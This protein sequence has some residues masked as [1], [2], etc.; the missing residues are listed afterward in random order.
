MVCFIMTVRG[1]S[2]CSAQICCGTVKLCESRPPN[3]PLVAKQNPKKVGEDLPRFG[4]RVTIQLEDSHAESLQ[5]QADRLGLSLSAYLRMRL[6]EMA[7]ES[8]KE[9]NEAEGTTKTR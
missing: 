2:I 3:C 1:S 5:Y 7:K 9:L 6:L 8:R 4:R